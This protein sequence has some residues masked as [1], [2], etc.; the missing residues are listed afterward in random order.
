MKFNFENIIKKATLGSAIVTASLSPLKSTGQEIQQDYENVKN[1][2]EISMDPESYRNEYIKY[3]E[4]PSYKERLAK[5][6][7]GD[8]IIDGDKQQNIDSE[9]EKRLTKIKNV[10]IEMLPIVDDVSKDTSHYSIIDKLVK[11]TPY[12]AFHELS[13]SLDHAGNMMVRQK[14]FQD[15]LY[16]NLDDSTRIANYDYFSRRSEIKA[17]LNS[18]R[19]KAVSLY[20]FDL[21]DNF[22]IKKFDK[23]RDDKEYLELRFNLNLTNEQ[24]NDLMKY[25]AENMSDEKDLDNSNFT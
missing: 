17:R 5:E 2:T 24:I 14:G 13:H 4:H 1:K 3:M 9:Y 23:L 12:A 19:L 16:K 15:A 10:P 8:E 18:L 21:N 6:M 7:Y 22:D 11:T 20:G 25:T